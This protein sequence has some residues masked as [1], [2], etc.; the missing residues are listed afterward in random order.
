MENLIF[1]ATI[2]IN[3]WIGYQSLWDVNY[4]EIFNKLN[5]IEKWKSILVEIKALRKTYT[6]HETIK[7]Y[8]AIFI[9]FTAAQYK[10][11]TRFD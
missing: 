9:D 1:E 11:N 5:D 7:E 6:S 8:G 2:Y 10:V 4:Q 3:N